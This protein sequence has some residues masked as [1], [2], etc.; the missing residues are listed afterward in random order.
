M[1]AECRPWHRASLQPL[2]A[3]DCREPASPGPAPSAD[4]RRLLRPPHQPA[5]PR[6]ALLSRRGALGDRRPLPRLG[7]PVKGRN[8]FLKANTGVPMAAAGAQ[9]PHTG[10]LWPLALTGC[11]GRDRGGD[12]GKLISVRPQPGRRRTST[13]QVPQPPA[14]FCEETGARG[15]QVRAGGRKGQ[16]GRCLGSVR[17]GSGRPRA[18][19]TPRGNAGSH[20]R[21][22][23]RLSPE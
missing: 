12:A 7:R 17:A 10:Q 19:L 15:R 6:P 21:M 18:G 11:A 23:A 20:P 4:G 2:P 3:H 14:G 8:P 5:P 22:L 9:G 16:V 1:G 13:S